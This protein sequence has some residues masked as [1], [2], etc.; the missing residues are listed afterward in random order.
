MCVFLKTR[1]HGKA[2]VFREVCLSP[3]PEARKAVQVKLRRLSRCL[4]R[5]VERND[6]WALRRNCSAIL[7]WKNLIDRVWDK[8]KGKGKG[9]R[10]V[11]EECALQSVLYNNLVLYYCTL[12][13]AELCYYTRM[14]YQSQN[15]SIVLYWH[16]IVLYWTLVLDRVPSPQGIRSVY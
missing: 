15:Y 8:E 12:C 16:I 3:D 11:I 7:R 2:E 13:S 10:I 6:T 14:L 4:S 1:E 5:R 9:L